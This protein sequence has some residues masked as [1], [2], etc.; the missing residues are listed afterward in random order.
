LTLVRLSAA[1]KLVEEAEVGMSTIVGPFCLY[2]RSLL[3]LVRLSTAQKLVEEAEVGM[4]MIV[5]LFCL[6]SRRDSRT[7]V[8]V[9]L[10]HVRNVRSLLPL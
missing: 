1:Q 10:S 4:S 2:S 9:T 6:Y 7:H 5:G 8:R 3:T